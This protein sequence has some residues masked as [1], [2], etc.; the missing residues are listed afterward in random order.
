VARWPQHVP[1]K[2]FSQ[3]TVYSRLWEGLHISL[4]LKRGETAK[5]REYLGFYL[6]VIGR[7]G[8]W[9][10]NFNEYIWMYFGHSFGQFLLDFDYFT[11]VSI[12]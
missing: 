11:G 2:S 9:I 12:K 10:L 6:E 8:L 3:R 7:Y 1:E 4:E 5:C